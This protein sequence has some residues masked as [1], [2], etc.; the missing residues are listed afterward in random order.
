MPQ[1][2]TTN[3]VAPADNAPAKDE[4]KETNTVAVQEPA[5]ADTKEAKDY[6]AI[7]HAWKTT[8]TQLTKAKEENKTLMRQLM[9]AKRDSEDI[10]LILEHVAQADGA[11]TL[12]SR[13]NERKASRA[14]SQ[15]DEEVINSTLLGF[16]FDAS[17]ER[18]KDAREAPNPLV[19]IAARARKLIEE[20]KLAFA[21]KEIETIAEQKAEKKKMEFL[22]QNKN[23]FTAPD[24]SSLAGGGE[25]T[26]EAIRNMTPEE[27]LARRDEIAKLPLGLPSRKR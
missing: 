11:E 23:K 10:N 26:A 22:E 21:G 6:A 25:L 13:L 2:E 4:S 27:R 18:F 14:K 7:E 19:A 3:V 12:K 20:E 24:G 9:D 17:D 5:K 1:D 8:Q 15:Q 16:G